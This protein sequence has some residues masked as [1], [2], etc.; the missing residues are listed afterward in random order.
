MIPNHVFRFNKNQKGRK[1]VRETGKKEKEERDRGKRERE[2]KKV[3][4]ILF[5]LVF[6]VTTQSSILCCFFS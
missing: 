2:K 6:G 1:R 4:E 5:Q 3:R